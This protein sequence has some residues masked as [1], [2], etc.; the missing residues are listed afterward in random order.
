[1]L[2]GLNTSLLHCSKILHSILFAATT[3]LF[4]HI[5]AC[6]RLVTDTGSYGHVM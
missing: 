1:M 4:K 3:I 5:F 2:Y 6:H